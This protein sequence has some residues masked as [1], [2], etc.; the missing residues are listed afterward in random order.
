MKRIISETPR[1]QKRRHH[2]EYPGALTPI[3]KVRM[4]DMDYQH[5][6]FVIENATDA[7]AEA[8]MNVILA[9]VDVLGLSLGGGYHKTSD[10]DY[11]EVGDVQEAA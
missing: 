6:D 8:L 4:T 2:R 9:I 11:P 10:D 3:T 1:P 5:F 7:Q